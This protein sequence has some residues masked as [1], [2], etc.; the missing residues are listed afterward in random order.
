MPC[1]D[2]A[3]IRKADCDEGVLRNCTRNAQM[4]RHLFQHEGA[5]RVRKLDWL[6]PE[7][8]ISR[9]PQSRDAF[10]LLMADLCTGL[11]ITKL[12]H[13]TGGA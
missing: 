9:R 2:R 8:L 13:R 4:N 3:P 11:Q 10:S 6:S 1:F 12:Q 5:V 7:P